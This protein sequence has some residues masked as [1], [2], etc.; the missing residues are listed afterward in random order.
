MRIQM[1]KGE[2][3]FP[4]R[5]STREGRIN[6]SVGTVAGKTS[7]AQ[8]LRPERRNRKK[9]GSEGEKKKRT[10]YDERQG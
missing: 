8:S 7:A 2:S 3:G 4:S 9:S 5:T 1:T 10:T 6:R